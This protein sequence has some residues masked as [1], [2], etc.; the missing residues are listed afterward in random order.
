MRNLHLEI[1]TQKWYH[2]EHVFKHQRFYKHFFH[3]T[4][5]TVQ[6][7]TCLH[8]QILPAE[9]FTQMC[10]YKGTLSHT[11]TH[12]CLQTKTIAHRTWYREKGFTYKKI[13]KIHAKKY[14][15]SFTQKH[16]DIEIFFST[17][18]VLH[19]NAFTHRN[20]RTK[21]YTT[22]LLHKYFFTEI[23][24]IHTRCFNIKKSLQTGISLQMFLIT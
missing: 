17:K 2:T 19:K 4:K 12:T 13:K 21:K 22:K 9:M 6:K 11:H 16:L 8:K 3:T 14:I 15:H 5:C 24:L 20:I 7:E 23:N 10:L 1:S 18:F